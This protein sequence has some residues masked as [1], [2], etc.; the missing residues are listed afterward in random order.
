MGT[1]ETAGG[2]G[3]TREETGGHERPREATG[4]H[5]R[6]RKATVRPWEATEGHLEVT[7]GPLEAKEASSR[8]QIWA[9]DMEASPLPTPPGPLQLHLLGE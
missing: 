1:R 2:H 5:K 9:V 3:R 8:A 6:P 4:G 7:G